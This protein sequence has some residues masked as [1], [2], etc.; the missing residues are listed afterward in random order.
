MTYNMEEGLN[1][2]WTALN[3]MEVTKKERSMDL[4]STYGVINHSMRAIGLIIQS[5]G[6]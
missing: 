1:H 4:E 5:V 2:G 6:K 3:M